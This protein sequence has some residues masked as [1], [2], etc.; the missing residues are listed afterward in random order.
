MKQQEKR[1]LVFC[2]TLPRCFIHRKEKKEQI[3]LSKHPTMAANFSPHRQSFWTWFFQHLTHRIIMINLLLCVGQSA[4]R[5]FQ[6][7]IRLFSSWGKKRNI[8]CFGIFLVLINNIGL[9]N[10]QSILT[11]TNT[12]RPKRF[13]MSCCGGRG[14]RTSNARLCVLSCRLIN[15]HC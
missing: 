10:H 14:W 3:I 8:K 6:Q 4:A 5:M 1:C 11:C 15:Y 12:T 13:F 7:L 9:D 2:A